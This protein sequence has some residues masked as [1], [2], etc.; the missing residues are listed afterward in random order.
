MTATRRPRSRR[1]TVRK[2]CWSLL[3]ADEGLHAGAALL[4]GELDR[5]RLHE[6]RRHRDQRAT[7]AAVLGDLG[8][9]DRV[10][11]DA[12]GVGGVPDLELVLQVQRDVAERA[13]L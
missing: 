5:R 13:A 8:R 12:G 11:D 2:S 3:A 9:A 10:D 7:D 6:V 4:V 1:V